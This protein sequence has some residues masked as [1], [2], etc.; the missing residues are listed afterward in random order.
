MMRAYLPPQTWTGPTLPDQPNSI[1][2]AKS[3]A[4]WIFV[5]EVDVFGN[6]KVLSCIGF[7]SLGNRTGIQG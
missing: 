2:L 4:C 1:L 3:G 5:I 6:K 7:W